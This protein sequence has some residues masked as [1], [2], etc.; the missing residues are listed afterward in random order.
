MSAQAFCQPEALASTP[1]Y[2]FGAYIK[3]DSAFWTGTGGCFGSKPAET[4]GWFCF[5]AQ[6]TGGGFR[7][8]SSPL[9]DCGF[10][11]TTDNTCDHS[12]HILIQNVPSG[13]GRVS[14]LERSPLRLGAGSATYRQHQLHIWGVCRKY[15]RHLRGC[16]W[17]HLWSESS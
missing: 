12:G 9:A 2:V 11:A 8:F 15:S 3:T 6:L 16:D 17:Q 1:A 10:G 5:G 7:L 13:L 14:T 4:R